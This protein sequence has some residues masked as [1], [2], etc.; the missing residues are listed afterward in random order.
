MSSIPLGYFPLRFDRD[1]SLNILAM[2]QVSNLVDNCAR[3]S[4]PFPHSACAPAPLVN[5]YYPFS[6]VVLVLYAL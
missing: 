2:M 3:G 5:L 4:M 6:L 1:Q